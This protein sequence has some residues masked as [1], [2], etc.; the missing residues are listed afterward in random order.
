VTESFFGL[1]ADLNKMLLAAYLA[2]VAWEIS[3]EGEPA[4]DLLRMTLNAFYALS[5]SLKPAALVKGVYEFRAAGLA[6]YLPELE[7]CALCGAWDSHD[8]VLDVLGGRLLCPACRDRLTLR[9]MREE[10]RPGR[11][12]TGLQD[13]AERVLYYTVRASVAAAIRY[14][15]SAP[16]ERMLAFEL[17]DTLDLA[18]FSEAGER[19]LHNH[20]ERGFES[21]ELYHTMQEDS[22]SLRKHLGD[23]GSSGT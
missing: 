16:I 4:D 7:R 22:I 9:R 8:M 5:G 18:Q 3:G 19:Y 21:L 17:K 14:A 6:G 15:L 10:A 11:N 12:T 13:E 20:L 2:D 23:V 1:H